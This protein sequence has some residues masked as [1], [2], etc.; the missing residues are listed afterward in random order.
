MADIVGFVQ[1]VGNEFLHGFPILS[2][3][4]VTKITKHIWRDGEMFRRHGVVAMKV[5]K[6]RGVFEVTFH[7]IPRVAVGGN[8]HQVKVQ[9]KG[10]GNFLR[11]MADSLPPPYK[12]L[13]SVY[14][15]HE[16]GFEGSY[17]S[18]RGLLARAWRS[19]MVSIPPR[20]LFSTMSYMFGSV[21]RSSL[22][23]FY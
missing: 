7:N 2:F 1:E 5:M 14:D 6:F 3:N 13:L 12:L 19:E 10:N 11:A 4:F 20:M 22:A 18:T 17:P 8:A 21:V 9:R 15:N 16:W 23:L